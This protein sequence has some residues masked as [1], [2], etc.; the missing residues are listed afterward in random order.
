MQSVCLVDGETEAQSSFN[1][2]QVSSRGRELPWTGH[3]A[4]DNWS[5]LR[6]ES[7]KTD[8]VGSRRQ[9]EGVPTAPEWCPCASGKVDTLF[10]GQVGA[11]KPL[12][13]WGDGGRPYSPV[14]GMA[15]EYDYGGMYFIIL[16]YKKFLLEMKCLQS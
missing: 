2:S 8:G 6:N 12:E 13:Q 15:Q 9:A 1:A 3:R 5:R 4:G 14:E 7:Q 16:H 11:P 10:W